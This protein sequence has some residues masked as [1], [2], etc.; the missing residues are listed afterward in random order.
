MPD[1]LSQLSAREFAHHVDQLFGKYRIE[2]Y[3]LGP[4]WIETPVVG[5]FHRVGDEAAAA[6]LK[7]LDRRA[8]AWRARFAIEGP[9]WGA[10]VAGVLA[11][12]L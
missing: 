5:L 4:E 8:L 6:A 2:T 1:E 9:P 11:E 10:A 7:E 12:P 3:S